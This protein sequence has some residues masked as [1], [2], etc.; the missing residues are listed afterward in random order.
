MSLNRGP[1][2][3][4]LK[5]GKRGVTNST[6][7][8]FYDMDLILRDHLTCPCHDITTCEHGHIVCGRC[9]DLGGLTTC[10]LFMGVGKVTV[11]RPDID[12]PVIEELVKR[13]IAQRLSEMNR[14]ATAEAE[15]EWRSQGMCKRALHY[16]SAPTALPQIFLMC[17]TTP[18]LLSKLH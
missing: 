11:T 8:R 1:T 10:P 16:L 5:H 2:V 12:K 6:R 7:G 9:R 3:V 15:A 4:K 18:K 17:N 14:S 13:H